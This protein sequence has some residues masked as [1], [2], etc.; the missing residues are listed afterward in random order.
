MSPRPRVIRAGER[1]GHLVVMA[2][3]QGAAK[4]LAVR[5]DCGT[6]HQVQAT[7]WGRTKSCGC[8]SSR[9]GDY[10][11]THGRSTTPEYQVWRNMLARCNNPGHQS[12]DD[13]G[14]RGIR[15]CERWLRLENF[16]ADMGDRP[17]P[18]LT[19]ERIDNSGPYAPDNCRW[20]TRA[21]QSSNRRKRRSCKRGHEFTPENTRIYRGERYCRTCARDRAR[22]KREA[23]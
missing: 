8:Q 9:T 12:Y 23:S 6:D 3:R 13:Y 22:A 1:Y 7:D 10:V 20:A 21:D 4:Y 5:C 11:R 16:H 18:D 19:I 14:G 17:G 15:V 2:D